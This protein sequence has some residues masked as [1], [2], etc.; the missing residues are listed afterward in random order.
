M[1]NSAQ[2]ILTLDALPAWRTA[3]RAQGQ[4]LVVTNGCFDILHVGHVTYLE[5]ARN[6]GDLLLVGLN[7]DGSVRQLKGSSRPVNPQQ[8]RALVLAALQCV[9]AVY[10]FP[11][12]RATHFLQVAQ[13]DIYVKGGFSSLAELPPEEVQVVES[14]GGRVVLVPMVPGKSTTE[15]LRRI[16]FNKPPACPARP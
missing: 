8:D 13:P 6:K 10:V 14:G 4:K 1:L 15:I 16:T 12:V 7:S 5:S 3:V 2:K 9:D 11:E